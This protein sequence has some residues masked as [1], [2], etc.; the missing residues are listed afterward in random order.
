MH[1]GLR[2][3]VLDLQIPSLNSR[4]V[5]IT[6]ILGTHVNCKSKVRKTETCSLFY[7]ENTLSCYTSFGMAE[8]SP[9][10]LYKVDIRDRRNIN[11]Q[12]PKHLKEL[13]KK[14]RKRKS[15]I[16]KLFSGNRLTSAQDFH[17]ASLIMQQERQRMIIN[18][19][20]LSQQ[21]QWKWET[22]RR[23]GSTPQ[24]MAGGFCQ[25][26]KHSGMERR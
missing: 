16:M 20:T 19:R 13:D 2:L 5:V 1:I 14:D 4:H 6:I 18:L 10:E 15:Q 11:F 3:S 21:R 24:H 9:E 23:A 7:C 8:I 17:H 12:N 22:N 25:T 26:D